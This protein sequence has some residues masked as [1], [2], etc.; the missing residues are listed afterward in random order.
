MTGLTKQF[1]VFIGVITT[2]PERLDVV[3]CDADRCPA[4]PL[5]LLA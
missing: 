2:V 3:D 5:A 1:L 4:L